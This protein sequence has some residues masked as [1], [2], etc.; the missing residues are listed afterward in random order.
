MA[1]A[2]KVAQANAVILDLL[3][4]GCDGFATLDGLRRLASLQHLPV[5]SWTGMVLTDAEYA[6][7]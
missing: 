2:A 5:F 6:S 3:V 7:L 4:P 1:A